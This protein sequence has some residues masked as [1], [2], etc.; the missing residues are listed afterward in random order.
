MPAQNNKMNIVKSTKL[1]EAWLH[2]QTTV[3]ASD[4]RDK[5]RAMAEAPFPFLRATFYRWL[6]LWDAHCPYLAGAPK[7]LGV[8]DLHVEN[9]GTWR[10]VEGRL[11]WGINDFDEACELAYTNDLVRLATSAHLAIA[12]EH[13]TINGD[14]AC[15]AILKG[16]KQGLKEGGKPFVLAEKNS[17][18]RDIATNELRDP[19]AFWEKMEALPKVR[20]KV[21]ASALDSL[22]K[23][24]PEIGLD[25]A[26]RRRVA[27]LG[28][29]GHQRFVASGD[30]HGGL[31]AREAK[32]LVPSAAAWIK[33][34]KHPAEIF[35]DAL[36]SRA[37]RC[38]DPF[39][40]LRGEWI[41]RRLSPFC[42]RIELADLP[43]DRDETRLLEAMGYE[44]AN[45]HWGTKKA[46]PEIIR[47][48]KK[49][50]K[51]WL[52]EAA[53]TMAKAIVADWKKWKKKGA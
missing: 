8:G 10:D 48:L 35:Y 53:G 20:G 29:L 41:V 3:V 26:I 14:D 34:G 25:Y 42:S 9:F 31:L 43:R 49:Q 1:Y 27:G 4:L 16:Y 51:D 37:V 32:A 17:W 47:H 12:A 13:I 11:I 38:P 30:W 7:V 6:Q 36:I 15:A 2:E 24:M 5:H 52:H 33:P 39:V 50:S 18:L 23:T 22:K 40:Q 19:V 28:S 44:T 21:P 45:I 46:A